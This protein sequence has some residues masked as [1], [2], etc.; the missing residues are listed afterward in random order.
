MFKIKVLMVFL[1][2]LAV[3]EHKGIRDA[4]TRLAVDAC[5]QDVVAHLARLGP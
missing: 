2:G 4:R 5:G 1:L 3:A